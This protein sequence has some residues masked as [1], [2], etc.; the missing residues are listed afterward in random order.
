MQLDGVPGSVDETVAEQRLCRRS[1]RSVDPVH[2]NRA[3]SPHA[4]L[5]PWIR[6]HI[7]DDRAARRSRMRPGRLSSRSTLGPAEGRFVSSVADSIEEAAEIPAGSR[8]RF[9][10]ST[11][12]A[13]W[14]ASRCSMGCH[15]G[16]ALHH[17]SAASAEADRGRARPGAG[18]SVAGSWSGSSSSSAHMAR[19]SS[20]PATWSPRVVRTASTQCLA[21][22]LIGMFGPRGRVDP[23]PRNGLESVSVAAEMQA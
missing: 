22:V 1:S 7:G 2:R 4:I 13:S 17:R 9:A 12:T 6:R 18:A 16:T 19:R 14:L 11:W 5:G 20:S 15:A 10:P 3:S 8:C 23:A 21:F